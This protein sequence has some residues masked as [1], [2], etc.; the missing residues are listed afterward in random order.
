MDPARGAGFR[1]FG[2]FQLP[3]ESLEHELG[4][5]LRLFARVPDPETE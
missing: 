5:P 3:R 4:R 2:Y 1:Y